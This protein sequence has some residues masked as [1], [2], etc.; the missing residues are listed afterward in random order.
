M[1]KTSPLDPD[2]WK[3]PT[4]PG[5]SA[6]TADRI[7]IEERRQARDSWRRSGGSD[8]RPLKSFRTDAE[9]KAAR[10][11]HAE[12]IHEAVEYVRTARGFGE[13]LEALELCPRL[14]PLN[15]ALIAYQC[16]GKIAETAAGWKQSGYQVRKGE[17]AAGWITGPMFYPRAIFTA[18]QVGA[19]D[20]VG[21]AE[22]ELEASALTDLAIAEMRSQ[23][24]A[25]LDAGAKGKDA[26]EAVAAS[27]RGE[28]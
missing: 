21:M 18:D 8:R 27:L 13:W 3:D 2:A 9:K 16:P 15:A 23:L 19:S 11:E 10:L 24:E 20:L 5:V 6:M 28:A 7:A 12:R 1:P 25:L 17:T 22:A 4:L 14:S 26:C